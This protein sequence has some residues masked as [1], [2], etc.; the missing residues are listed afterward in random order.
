[1]TTKE[2]QSRLVVSLQKKF[3]HVEDAWHAFTRIKN[4]YGPR[5]DVAI[6]PFNTEAALTNIRYRYNKL[7]TE[8][9]LSI[10][11]T[12]SPPMKRPRMPGG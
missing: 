4:R 1:M 5:V 6:G 2:Y 11:L 12:A 10:A 8:D 3:N 9:P 7:V